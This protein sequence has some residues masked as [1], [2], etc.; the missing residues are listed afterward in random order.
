MLM[1]IN[2]DT[3]IIISSVF[4]NLL[5]NHNLL[6][7]LLPDPHLDH[8]SP[9]LL[10]LPPGLFHEFVIISKNLLS[11]ELNEIFFVFIIVII[12]IEIIIFLLFLR[13]LDVLDT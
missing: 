3:Y 1:S 11:L 9:L 2:I 7:L 10:V 12:L 5:N 8:E 4:L 6:L 13:T